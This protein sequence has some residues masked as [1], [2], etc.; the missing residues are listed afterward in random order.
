[1]LALS[2]SFILAICS[3]AA[4]EWQV[5][6]TGQNE[7]YDFDNHKIIDCGNTG[8]DGS[9]KETTN[10]PS[11]TKL[12]SNGEVL[13][14][15]AETWA[16]VQDNVTGLIWEVKTDSNKSTTYT[17]DEADAYVKSLSLGESSAEWRLPTIK[18]L[19]FIVN[20]GTAN[21]S[22]NKT[23]FANTQ[24]D[25]YWSSDDFVPQADSASNEAWVVKFNDGRVEYVT[26]DKSTSEHYVRAVRGDK[27]SVSRFIDNGDGTVTDVATKLMWKQTP[28]SMA[29]K[30]V[31]AYCEEL[32]FPEENGYSDWRAPNINEL[33][34][35]ADY[36]KNITINTN[37]FPDAA[38]KYYWSSTT[39]AEANENHH[40]W[41]MG[42]GGDIYRGDKGASKN[43]LPV[44]GPVDEIFNFGHAILGLK[45]LAGLEE[46]GPYLDMNG[47]QK[48][49]LEDIIF[50]LRNIAGL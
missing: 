16:M 22:V 48:T 8:Q 24:S 25:F 17:W 9:Y 4:A 14:D 26:H 7:C 39:R 12:D 21:P 46:N 31:P 35:L 36:S 44:R 27:L 19:A 6:D 43:V 49:G 15:D 2:I 29:W 38:G 42:A 32:T 11:Y 37:A 45:A 20:R 13:P 28:E 3:Y 30:D 18:E 47:D 33:Q 40:A 23:Y 50:V 41:Y 1:M 5:P 10:Q 34:S